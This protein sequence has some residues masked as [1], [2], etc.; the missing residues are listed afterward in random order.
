MKADPEKAETI[1]SRLVLYKDALA[2]QCAKVLDSTTLHAILNDTSHD[3]LAAEQEL[4]MA[5]RFYTQMREQQF[6]RGA[7]LFCSSPEERNAAWLFSRS[8]T[9]VFDPSNA[10]GITCVKSTIE[11]VI[12]Q[13]M[14][15]DTIKWQAVA[16]QD[17]K[18]RKDLAISWKP[19]QPLAEDT[20]QEAQ[21]RAEFAE[22]SLQWLKN[23]NQAKFE[24][25]Y[26]DRITDAIRRMF[27]EYRD[28]WAQRPTEPY[29]DSELNHIFAFA[30]HGPNHG[31]GE[32]FMAWQEYLK[33]RITAI[34]LSIVPYEICTE[35]E[36]TILKMEHRRSLSGKF[37]YCHPNAR[38]IVE[39]HIRSIICED[40]AADTDFWTRHKIGVE[41]AKQCYHANCL[42]R[43]KE[44]RIAFISKV[45]NTFGQQVLDLISEEDVHRYSLGGNSEENLWYSILAKYDFDQN[46]KSCVY[47]IRQGDAIKIGITDNL[48]QRF[49]QIKTS[50]ALPCKIESVVYT[51]YGKMLERKLHQAFADYN[52]HLEWFVLPTE[53][54]EMLF[55][56]KSAR[57]IEHILTRATGDK[58]TDLPNNRAAETQIPTNPE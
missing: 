58:S 27:D 2:K 15:A 34:D 22:S 11:T 25:Y 20:A 14:V 48:D 1:G 7:F 16:V 33:G 32:L 42:K 31:L 41:N 39:A 56:A 53:I 12:N 43:I 3:P 6:S 35:K 52:N 9:I 28:Y 24:K 23:R 21:A 50:A 13:D 44:R 45:R 51:H 49:A 38:E 57:D 8:K 10:K 54:E 36:K 18:W 30:F 19:N 26:F 4:V 46:T 55:A 40:I 5:W 37:S 29:V 17:E 47:F